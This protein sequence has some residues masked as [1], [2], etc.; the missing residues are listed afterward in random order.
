MRLAWAFFKRDATIAL[1][2]RASFA[3][4]LLGNLLILG[5]FYFIGKT[6]ANHPLPALAKYGGSF[7]AF[8]LIGIALTDCVGVSI[9]IFA[10]QIRDGQ[11]TGTLEATLMSPARLSVILVDSS[12]WAYFFSAIRFLLY[13]A[14]GS[15]LYGVSMRQANIPSAA[16]IFLLTILCFMGIGILW[17]SVIMIVKR[18]SA[19]LM[20]VGFI[21]IIVSGALFP[22][23]VLPHWMQVIGSFIPLT[24]ALDGMRLALLKGFTPTLL[25]NRMAELGIF[26]VLSLGVGLTAFEWAVKAAMR[27]GSLTEY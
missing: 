12:L 3:V 19:I 25:A 22:T 9:T 26:A 17:A 5:I 10:N 2:Y 20:T 21:T 16:I 18:G 8:A 27:S 14:V 15:V 6:V 1:S 24:P 11:T 13:L 23:A 4:Q 7:L